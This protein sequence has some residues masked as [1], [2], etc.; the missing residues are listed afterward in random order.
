MRYRLYPFGNAT[1]DYVTTILMECGCRYDK[2]R[3]NVPPSGQR[4]FGEFVRRYLAR[5]E[6]HAPMCRPLEPWELED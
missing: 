5:C 4:V 3:I 2:F 1:V 6:D